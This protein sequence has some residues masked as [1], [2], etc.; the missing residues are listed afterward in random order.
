MNEQRRKMWIKELYEFNKKTEEEI[1]IML[2]IDLSE[3]QSCI[4]EYIQGGGVI[5]NIDKIIPDTSEE[6][7]VEK[8]SNRDK[9]KK[10]YLK[11]NKNYEEISQEL[12]LSPSTVKLYIS[13]G[14]Y[15]RNPRRKRNRSLH[16]Q[17]EAEIAE[18]EH[19]PKKEIYNIKKPYE[20]IGDG[21]VIYNGRIM[22]KMT[23]EEFVRYMVA[24]QNKKI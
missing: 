4:A 19:K 8:I 3:V 15:S 16:K 9:V 5:M 24:E 2:D 7:E 21:Y 11:D 20:D 6:P 12:G 18:E 10:L 14:G 17:A 13:Q 1:S 22:K 23:K